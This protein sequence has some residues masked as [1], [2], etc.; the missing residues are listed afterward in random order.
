M[1]KANLPIWFYWGIPPVF[2]QPL[3]PE[4]LVFAPRSHPQCRARAPPL[5]A[6]TPSQSVGLP[7]SSTSQSI[8]VPTPS[9]SQSVTV[10][11]PTSTSQ[12]DSLP[13]RSALEGPGQLHGETWQDFMRRQNLWQEKV[14]SKENDDDRQA[15]EG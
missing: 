1:F 8:S 13:G 12:P 9:T 7:T 10:A 2:V 4:A 3:M 14:L 15:R 11:L 5:P 6:I